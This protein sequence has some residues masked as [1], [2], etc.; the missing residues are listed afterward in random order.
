MADAMALATVSAKSIPAVRMVALRSYDKR[1]FVF[2]TNYRS[3]KAADISENPRVALV[4]YW[5]ELDRQ[6]RIVGAAEKISKKESDEY[7]SSRPQGSNFVQ[8]VSR[9]SQVVKDKETVKR[10]A[11][12][13]KKKHDKLHLVR[14]IHWGGISHIP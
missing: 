10:R 2:H 7:F 8:V 9:Q 5:K 14:P 12:N 11:N 6:V 13:S 4:F 1:G 3:K